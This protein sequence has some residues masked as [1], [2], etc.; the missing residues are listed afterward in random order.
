MNLMVESKIIICLMSNNVSLIK[1]MLIEFSTFMNFIESKIIK[2]VL[3]QIIYPLLETC[4]YQIWKYRVAKKNIRFVYNN[5]L[6]REYNIIDNPWW[7]LYFIPDKFPRFWR[8]SFLKRL[9]R[10]QT[11]LFRAETRQIVGTCQYFRCFRKEMLFARMD[12]ACV[13]M[14]IMELSSARFMRPYTRLEVII[15][16]IQ[17]YIRVFV[18]F[19]I[20]RNSPI[21]ERASKIS[22]LF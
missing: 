22:F 14:L 12:I 1:N 9:I 17:I 20:H 10:L 6:E 13:R 3:C 19:F 15:S 8:T 5:S 2:F 11:R 4:L 21:N 18:C 16:M 7:N